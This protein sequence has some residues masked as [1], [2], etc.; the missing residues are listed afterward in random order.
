MQHIT[1]THFLLALPHFFTSLLSNYLSRC[2]LSARKGLSAWS[3]TAMIYSR[4]FLDSTHWFP[5]ASPLEC[6]TVLLCR[7]EANW[8]QVPLAIILGI[9]FIFSLNYQV[10]IFYFRGTHPPVAFKEIVYDMECSRDMVCLLMSSL[11]S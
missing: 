11:C 3:N 10:L 5:G 2:E 6:Y 1:M 7:P 4:L 8:Y 9:S